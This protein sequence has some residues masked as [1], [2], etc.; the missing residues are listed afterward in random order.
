MTATTNPRPRKLGPD[1]THL[2]I[3]DYGD[4]VEYVLGHVTEA[5]FLAECAR[6]GVAVERLKLV[7]M[8]HRYGRTSLCRCGD[9]DWDLETYDEPGRGRFRL[10]V[11]RF[12]DAR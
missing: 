5:E 9:H 11:G 6:A 7:R 1:G 3:E 12:D 4:D 10:T 8:D 2:E